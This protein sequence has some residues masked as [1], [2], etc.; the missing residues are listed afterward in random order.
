MHMA[1]REAM[2]TYSHQLSAER[3]LGAAPMQKPLRE[4][5]GK[6]VT[7]EGKVKF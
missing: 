3:L 6:T 7:E 5:V 4:A 1:S 2:L